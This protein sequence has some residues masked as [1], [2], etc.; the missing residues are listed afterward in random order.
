MLR[1]YITY[2]II[3]NENGWGT[4]KTVKTVTPPPVFDVFNEYLYA[5][6]AVFLGVD[7]PLGPWAQK[8]APYALF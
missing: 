7:L 5:L 2:I 6:V 4:R 3:V 8:R 1:Y